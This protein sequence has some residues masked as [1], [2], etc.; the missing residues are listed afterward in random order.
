MTLVEVRKQLVSVLQTIQSNSGLACPP[1]TGT[2][3]PIE[4]LEGFDSKIWPVAI[5]MLAAGLKI[6]I[7][8]DVNIFASGDGQMPLSIDETAAVV[9]KLAGEAKKVTEAAE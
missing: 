6:E 1:I 7:A 5:G 2:L 4:Q 3:K 9:C 8:D